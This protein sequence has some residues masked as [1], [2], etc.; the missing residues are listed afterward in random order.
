MHYLPTFYATYKLT[1]KNAQFANYFNLCN[2]IALSQEIFA[3]NF[4]T[5]F[6]FS[7]NLAYI[8]QY[9]YYIIRAPLRKIM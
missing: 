2:I 9:T 8:L 5:F 4:R 7:A 6:C 1:A 3:N